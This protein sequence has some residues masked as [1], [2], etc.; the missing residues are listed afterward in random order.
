MA[1][2]R[3]KCVFNAELAKKY[4]FMEK[5]ENKTAS[6]VHCNTCN[7]DFNIAFAGKSDIERHIASGKH[8]DALQAASTSRTVT[9]FFPSATDY[10]VA[11]CEGVWSYHV[12][13]A[14]RTTVF[15]DRTVLHKYFAHV[16]KFGNFTALR[17]NVKR[18]P[19]TCLPH[20]HE[21]S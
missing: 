12:I 15:V 5:V 6:D 20:S 19:Q 11:A 17:P 18:L 16:S 8:K 7:S 2:K 21:T 1:P 4:P 14:K 10:N 9:Q 13:Q 3:G